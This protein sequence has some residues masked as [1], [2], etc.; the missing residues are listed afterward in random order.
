MI[1][2]KALRDAFSDY[3]EALLE[4]YDVGD[5]LYRL[6]GGADRCRRRALLPCLPHG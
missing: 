6:T 5:V 4:R 2:E 3:A 1:D